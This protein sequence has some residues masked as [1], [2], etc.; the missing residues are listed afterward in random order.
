MYTTTDYIPYLTRGIFESVALGALSFVVASAVGLLL[1]LIRDH[2]SPL[3]KLVISIYIGLFRALP[4]LLFILFTYYGTIAFT[5]SVGISEP[6]PFA[7]ALLAFGVQI[8]S[9]ACQIFSDAYR[10]VPRGLLEAAHAVGMPGHLINV[11]I[12][13]PLMLRLAAPSLGSLLLGTIKGTALA[14]V[15]GV[16]EVTRRADIVAG[17]THDALTAFGYA[18]AIYL[19]ISAIFTTFQR[20][21]EAAKQL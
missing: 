18:A 16:T 13:I 4:E 3:V 10:A 8:G 1:A 17:S 9:Y 12:A 11:R 5:R 21:L 15:I 20:R 7:A 14:S 2:S 6:S 19:A